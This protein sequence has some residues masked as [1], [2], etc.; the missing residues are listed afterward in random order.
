[1]KSDKTDHL[2]YMTIGAGDEGWGIV[3]TTVG[4]QFIPPL[5]QYPLSKHPDDYNFK[6][7]AG[8]V[9]NEY[10]LIYI[11][12]GGGYFESNSCR[13]QR[14]QAGTMILL[15]PGEWHSYYPDKDSGWDEYWVGFKGV[16]IDR[17]VENSYFSREEPLFHIGLSSSLIDL[18]GQVLRFTQEERAG[19]QQI[20]SS[21]VLHMLGLVYYKHKNNSFTNT[22]VVDR[23]NQAR[24][25]MKENID[26]PLSPEDIAA[27]LGLGYT[28]FRRMFK[29]YT[30]VSPAQYQQQ[31]RILQAKKL[32]T[33]T[34][35][36]ISDIAYELCFESVGQF[37][38]FFRKR[39][40]ITPSEFRQRNH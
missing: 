20:I 8:R 11:T 4:Y 25:M 18:Y 13:A 39:E 30:G 2:R 27:R 28:W 31:L 40:G 9:L 1:M 26:E 21:I 24:I 38:T 12:S 6:P 15:F 33:S 17:R 35:K 3:V 19:Y 23:I 34:E 37:S 7:Q 32:L 5:S 22:Y 36:S 29:E 10:Q 14:I 16:H